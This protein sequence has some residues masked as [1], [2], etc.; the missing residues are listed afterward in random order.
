MCCCRSCRCSGSIGCG[1]IVGQPFFK[2][3]CYNLRILGY[4][5]GRISNEIVI[6]TLT[7]FIL[8]CAL[9]FHAFFLFF[10][11]SALFFLF[12]ALTLF[13]QLNFHAPFLTRFWIHLSHFSF[14]FLVKLFFNTLLFQ[15]LV[16]L[17][18]K[19]NW[20]NHSKE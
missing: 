9:F 20:S 2:D 6:L 13:C 1:G 19:E 17:G 18:W 14:N 8:T 7:F 15:S 3:C 16:D 11:M 4:K 5:I 10:C 12:H